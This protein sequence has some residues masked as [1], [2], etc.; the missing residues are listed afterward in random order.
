MRLQIFSSIAAVCLTGL[1]ASCGGGSSA[2]SPLNLKAEVGETS[3]TLSWNSVPNVEYWLF[4]APTIYAPPDNSKMTLWFNLPGGNVQRAVNQPLTITGLIPDVPYSL[5]VN[6]RIDGGPGGP[7]APTLTVTPR[8]AGGVWT[9]GANPVTGSPT[10]NG[11]VF[12]GAF[13]AVGGNGK[14]FASG[15]ARTWDEVTS[16]TTTHLNGVTYGSVNPGGL[17]AVGDSG[18][19]LTSGNGLTWTART[20]GTTAKLNSVAVNESTLS[21]AVGAGGTIITSA[22]GV[23]W[24][25]ATS[26]GTT[27]DLYE[28]RFLSNL[29]FAVGANGTVVKSVDA[30]TWTAQTTN[31]TASLRSIAYTSLATN[32]VSAFVVVGAAGKVLTSDNLATAN[33]TP[34]WKTVTGIPATANLNSVVHGAQFVA[35]GDAGVTFTST[36][37]LNWKTV[38]PITSQNLLAVVRGPSMYAALGTAGTNLTSK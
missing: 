11:M 8:L 21:V 32:S 7:A 4:Y 14:I 38:T 36:D 35:V 37:G 17:I 31:T 23:T 25:P 30:K 10:M 13:V 6:G 2:E 18:T 1:L 19:L 34:T 20:S 15:N 33:G 24:A 29:W 27:Q 16:P 12:T 5:T 3:V 26:S 28:V 22:D 9:S